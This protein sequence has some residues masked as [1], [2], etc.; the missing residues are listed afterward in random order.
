VRIVDLA[1]DVGYSREGATSR[2]GAPRLHQFGMAP[3]LVVEIFNNEA[4]TMATMNFSIPDD[5]KEA[6]NKAFEG[7]NK[8]AVI[9]RLMVRAIEEEERTRRSRSFV[10]RLR[11]IRARGR[12]VTEDEIR[13]AREE[14]RK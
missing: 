5:V 13:R 4:D 12:P 14:L 2:A 10:E 11:Q 9:T 3:I 8:S 1:M 6:F 7:E